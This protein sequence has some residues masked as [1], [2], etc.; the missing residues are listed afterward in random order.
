VDN[1]TI[2][3]MVK[4]L[5]EE[6]IQSVRLR[7]RADVPVGIYLSG[8]LDSSMITGITKHLVETEG[9]ALGSQSPTD[10]ITAFTLGINSDK[11]DQVFN[12]SGKSFSTRYHPLNAAFAVYGSSTDPLCIA[13]ARRTAESLGIRHI[14]VDADEELMANNFEDAAYHCE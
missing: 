12:E 10:R 1:R 3:D 4:Q 2:E 9:T 11:G 5:R 8:G 14:V 7:L 13:F 6:L